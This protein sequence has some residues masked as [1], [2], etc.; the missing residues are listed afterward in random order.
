MENIFS[1]NKK[2]FKKHFD[3]FLQQN[4]LLKEML[5]E[6]FI[7]KGIIYIVGGFIRDFLYNKPSR[8]IDMIIDLDN[9]ILLQIVQQSKIQHEINRHGGIKLL[10]KNISVDMWS[11]NENWAFKKRLVKLNGE[12]KL[13]SIAKGCFYNFDALAINILDFS[14]NIQYYNDFIANKS[15]NILQKRSIYKLLNPTKEANILRAFFLKENYNCNFSKNT[16]DYLFKTIMDLSNK[17]LIIEK[18][19]QNTLEKY[20]KYQSILTKSIIDS[21]IK[22]ILDNP[23]SNISQFSLDLR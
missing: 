14:Y 11:I 9:H 5:F 1:I 13:H 17:D 10:L 23:S 8:D 7:N 15:L 6:I 2:E 21:N 12:D 22:E 16:H 3:V 4:T 20:P 18:H 19:L